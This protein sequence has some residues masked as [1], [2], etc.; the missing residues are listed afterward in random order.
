M[1]DP[2]GVI[3]QEVR[4]NPAVRAIVGQ[5]SGVWKVAG[6]ESRAQ[7]EPPFV[8][9]VRLGTVRRVQFGSHR[10]GMQTARYAANCFG[11][12]QQ[13]AAQ[14]Y[15]A[16]SDALHVKGPRR[17]AQGRQLYISLEE[18]GGQPNTQP[19]T[20]WP[21]ETAVFNVIAAAQAAA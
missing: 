16:V 15:G 13:Q 18:V 9:V 21:Y 10:A 14:L 4:D 7:W 20:D 2:T 17:D 5:Y 8:V 11:A 6:G 3:V 19:G 1:I 12:T